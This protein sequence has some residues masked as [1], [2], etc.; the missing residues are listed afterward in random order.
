MEQKQKRLLTDIAKKRIEKMNR[1]ILATNNK[2]SY[3]K[4][5]IR[6]IELIEM[7]MLGHKPMTGYDMK[8]QI[9]LKLGISVNN[10]TVYRCLWRLTESKLISYKKDNSEQNHL[11]KKMYRLTNEGLLALKINSGLILNILDRSIFYEEPYD[12]V[13]DSR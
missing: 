11:E 8:K 7:I 5:C 4:V 3:R 12:C 2:E 1:N 9:K 10:V 6:N 13:L